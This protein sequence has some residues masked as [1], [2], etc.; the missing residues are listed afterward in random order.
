MAPPLSDEDEIEQSIESL[1]AAL[2]TRTQELADALQRQA[3]TT[4]I[5][6]ALNRSTFNLPEVL[7]RLL[8]SAARLGSADIGTIRHRE[9]DTYTL[10]ATYGCTPEWEADFQRYS[11]KPDRGSV[12]GRT[13]L[14]R[15]TVH[16]PDVLADP[17]FTRHD[18]Q[19][20]MGFHAA[21]GVPLVRDDNVL[22][23][24]IL[25]R[26]EKQSFTQH[27]IE[28]V[29]SFA[30]QAVIAI[31]NTRLFLEIQEKSR[32]VEEQAAELTVLN[33]T[34]ESRV[35]D[36]VQQIGR[37]SKL[38]RFLSPKIST[39][40]MAGE[41]DDPLKTR[42]AEI[43]VVYVDLRGFTA[44]TETADPEE[45]MTVL[46]EYHAAL[47]RAITAYDGTI[48]HFA[49]DGA[50]ILFNAPLPMPDHELCAIEM[51]LEI[52]TSV[53]AL[54]A[55]W[56]KRGFDLGFGAGIAAGYATIGTI[57]FEQ[58]LD[59]SAIGNVC[60]LAARLC[61]EAQNAQILISPRIFAKV[62][63]LVE[64]VSVGDLTLKGFQRPVA[65]YDVVALRDGAAA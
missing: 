57:G 36:Q 42:R 32:R 62:E 10:A 43:T 64:L 28:L 4:E 29:E 50:M 52:R 34:L 39:L 61:G 23:A 41:A 40:I 18:A 11:T 53:T 45:V 9:G 47:G 22:G 59:Y 12:Y 17:E 51:A 2:A 46:R 55:E 14:D 1:S 25:F 27:Q 56:K 54:S 26:F 33:R 31:E 8:E 21:L 44:F 19:K 16:I 24:L 48:E 58:R 63:P 5:L 35:A 37:I 6:R 13:M 49:G 7:N 3:A 65:A 38:T 20:L 60:N 30:E 15:R